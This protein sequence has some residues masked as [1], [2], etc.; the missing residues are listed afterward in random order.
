M[1]G[2]G[3]GWAG[4]GVDAEIHDLLNLSLYFKCRFDISKKTLLY[5]TCTYAERFIDKLGKPNCQAET[6]MVC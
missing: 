5:N 1:R 2:E 3:A 6:S 4:E